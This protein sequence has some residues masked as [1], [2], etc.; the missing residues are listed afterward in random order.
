M[1][2]SDSNTERGK[3][4]SSPCMADEV[5]EPARI[6]ERS[7]LVE[8]LNVLVEGER[9][10][11]QGLIAMAKAEVTPEFKAL[12]NEVAHDEAR[13]C[14]M[15]SHHVERFGGTPNRATGVFAEK[16]AQRET[17]IDKL[18][19]LDKGQSVVVQILNDILP[20][21]TDPRLIEDLVEMR[22]IH[23]VNINRCNDLLARLTD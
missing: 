5:G 8:F 4:S 18:K 2:D 3:P 14:A 9:A 19:L 21:L 13:F 12:L 15:L 7:A 10:G 17:M 23:V 11:A 22:D 20:E 16:L 1:S 6:M